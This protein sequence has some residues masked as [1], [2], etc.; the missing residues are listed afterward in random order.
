MISL[1]LVK[2]C[3]EICFVL[4]TKKPCSVGQNSL[5]VQRYA[6]A[7]FRKNRKKRKKGFAAVNHIS[8]T[9]RHTFKPRIAL[10]RESMEL[11]N[12]L[13]DPSPPTPFSALKMGSKYKMRHN[14]LKF[15]LFDPFF[16]A[17]KDSQSRAASNKKIKSRVTTLPFPLF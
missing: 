14:S 5:V 17:L 9:T 6:G 7:K 10:E 2:I 1:V 4:K 11:Q 12:L 8:K 13:S 16:I 3:P 15:G